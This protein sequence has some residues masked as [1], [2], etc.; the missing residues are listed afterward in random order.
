[1]TDEKRTFIAILL[2]GLVLLAYFSDPY[3]KLVN[4]KAF[5]VDT[6]SVVNANQELV[7]RPVETAITEESIIDDFKS[8]D[9]VEPS[10]YENAKTS[11]VVVHT[12][13][14]EIHLS[15]LGGGTL[16]K[17]YLKK[18]FMKDSSLVQL[19]PQHGRGVLSNQF[20]G[21]E[22]G[23][24]STALFPST[25]SLGDSPELSMSVNNSPKSLSFTMALANGGQIVRTFTFHP[26]KYHFDLEQ[27]LNRLEKSVAGRYFA[28]TWNGGINS[29]E[30]SAK[31]D[32]TYTKIYALLGSDSSPSDYDA[33]SDRE[34]ET[35]TGSTVWTGVRNKYFTSIMVPEKPAYEIH[36]SRQLFDQAEPPYKELSFEMRQAYNR[37]QDVQF[38]N[39]LV[40]IG[41]LE[42]DILEQYGLHFEEMMDWGWF[43]FLGKG[44]LWVLKKLYSLI[45]N[46]GLVII[47]FSILVKVLISPLTKKS[48]ASTQMMQTISPEINALKEKYKGNNKRVQEETMKL[49]KEKGVNPVGG[50]L[51]MV[52][53]MPLLFALF[54]LFRTTIELRGAAFKGLE[55]W[56]PDLSLP[57]TVGMIAGV[58]INIL[59][60]IMGVTMIIQQKMSAPS[61]AANPQMKNMPYFMTVFFL[62]IFY[63]FPSGLNLY[64]TLFNLLAIIQQKNMK[65]AKI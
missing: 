23:D 8:I 3:Q 32:N 62:F 22:K 35:Q 45:P 1:M 58:P 28:T 65:P 38:S 16:E 26:D 46:Y 29:C 43:G 19:I 40:Y 52:I 13:L 12:P 27:R 5:E 11:I 41:P 59:P 33:D 44:A 56:I 10:V 31:E 42:I 18:Y 17:V 4:P 55:F 9:S 61:A 24:L 64:Y 34:T 57:D 48:F 50:C 25:C 53:Q 14:Y 51:P 36:Q 60:V 6:S 47:L 49:Y 37:K 2:M 7:S 21:F 15:T 20:I 30:P 39:Y 54:S 63:S